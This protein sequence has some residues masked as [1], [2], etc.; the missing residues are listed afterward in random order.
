MCLRLN[1]VVSMP[2]GRV[3]WGSMLMLGVWSRVLTV[4]SQN[5]L[6]FRV[7]SVSVLCP[8]HVCVF[9]RVML[10]SRPDLK[11]L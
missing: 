4:K 9:A 6:C 10:A 11:P 8:T 3:V 1:S 2:P 5:M 7:C